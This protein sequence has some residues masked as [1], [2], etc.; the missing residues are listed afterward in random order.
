VFDEILD[1]L[2][3]PKLARF[4]SAELRD[5]LLDQ[6]I[7]AA[8]WFEPAVTVTDC[9]DPAD[10]KYLEL[11]LDARATIIVSDDLDLLVLHPWRGIQILRPG[12]YVTASTPTGH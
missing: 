5:D 4:V 1:V 7:S 6:L 2:H 12:D 11:A 10:N 3:R 9:R 8:T